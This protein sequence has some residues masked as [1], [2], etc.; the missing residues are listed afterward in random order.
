[1]R[2]ERAR[3]PVLPTR[4]RILHAAMLRFSMTSY[5]ETG[6]GDIAADVGVDVAY[7][8]RCFGSKERLFT[9]VVA[10]TLETRRFL[11]NDHDDWSHALAQR[12]FSRR[13][14]TADEVTPF[15]VILRSLL[16]PVAAPVLQHYVLNEL[17]GSLA[18]AFGHADQRPAAVITALLVGMGLLRNVLQ[19]DPL[20]EPAGGGLEKILTTAVDVISGAGTRTGTEKGTAMPRRRAEMSE[21]RA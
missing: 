10:T 20:L 4:E 12:V 17:I 9:E 8:H 5:E 7:V 19:L 16:S 13:A 21:K 11:A 6:L 1:M 18:A 2:N 15:D 14:A 3:Q